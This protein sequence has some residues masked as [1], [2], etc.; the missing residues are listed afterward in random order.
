MIV[1]LLYD[2]GIELLDSLPSKLLTHP[3]IKNDLKRRKKKTSEILLDLAVHQSALQ[4]KEQTNRGRIDIVHHC[5]LQFLFSSLVHP[6]G[7]NEQYP[8][9]KLLVHSINDTY[10]EVLPSWRPPSHFIRFRGLL[11]Q[12][13]T[14]KWLKISS[15]ETI[16]LKKGT[17]DSIVKKFNPKTLLLFTSHGNDEPE[18]LQ[19]FSH[20]ISK[21]YTNSE[22]TVCLIGGYQH[23]APP[24]SL[25]DKI[26]EKNINTS[27]ITLEGG[28]LPSWKVLEL[29]LHAIEWDLTS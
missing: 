3:T 11:E 4:S 5:I 21:F 22:T 14:K 17:I 8:M 25:V 2:C 16:E 1:F 27:T 28:R 29:A 18:T 15:D 9:P 12:L 20:D 13:Y 10:F 19:S 26:D 24:K 6:S 23:G 7:K